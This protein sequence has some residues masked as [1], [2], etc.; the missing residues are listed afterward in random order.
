MK[1]FDILNEYLASGTISAWKVN[2]TK[3]D[4][5]E[6][7]FVHESLETV[8]ATDS[9]VSDVT[10][11]IDG[12]DTTGDSGFSFF[13]GAEE[14][15]IRKKIE[16]AAKRAGLVKNQKYSLVSGGEEDRELPGNMT[17][18][19]MKVIAKEVAD[20]VFTAKADPG[21]SVN[22]L[23][24]FVYHDILSVYNS[25]GVKKKQS[26]VRVMIEAIPTFTEG[27]DSVELY[28]D[29]RFTTLDKEVIK[30]EISK[31]LKE[32]HDRYKA[33]KPEVPQK[34]DV[35]I[36]P[37]E[38]RGL[39]REL[40]D[41]IGY[42]SVYSHMNTM[43]PG[44]DI[45]KGGSGDK[46][47]GSLVG[48]IEGS[49]RSAY[50]DQDGLDLTD[51]VVIENGIIKNNHGSNRFGQY[52]GVEKPSGILP[53]TKLGAGSL[54]EEEISKERYLE[55]VSMSGIQIDIYNDYIGGEI[56][57]AYLVENGSKTPVT[58]ITMSG[59]LK[60]A[61]LNMRLADRTVRDGSY[62]GPAYMMIKEMEI[63]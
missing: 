38:I 8:R 62:E 27:K 6:L 46:L 48:R 53:C 26:V 18:T 12:D 29:F 54:T 17:D 24:I 37:H 7:F 34:I 63:L 15:D 22:A 58:G 39:V 11:Y 32:V 43:N 42:A 5:Y 44:D 28:E 31:K 56:R 16:A 41:D 1:I 47:N 13:G 35:V 36:P 33:R 59:S 20:A 3:T 50:F 61:L 21:A 60:S 57:L 55:I 52:L 51:T 23:E 30:A 2:E 49:E 25:L 45:Q 4:S 14:D 40:A 9:T 19:D 10:V